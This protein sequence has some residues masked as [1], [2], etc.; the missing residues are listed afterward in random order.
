MLIPPGQAYPVLEPTSLVA[1][2]IFQLLFYYKNRCRTESNFAVFRLQRVLQD[3]EATQRSPWA[4]KMLFCSKLSVPSQ[5]QYLGWSQEMCP[6]A[7]SPAFEKYPFLFKAPVSSGTEMCFSSSDIMPT[8][9]FCLS[10]LRDWLGCCGKQTGFLLMS[11]GSCWCLLVWRISRKLTGAALKTMGTPSVQGPWVSHHQGLKAGA[12]DVHCP[13][14][15]LLIPSCSSPQLW[16]PPRHVTEALGSCSTDVVLLCLGPTEQ[17]R[18]SKEHMPQQWPF[19]AA[20]CPACSEPYVL[21]A[22]QALVEKLCLEWGRLGTEVQPALL[23]HCSACPHWQWESARRKGAE[24]MRGVACTSRGFILRD[25]H[26]GKKAAHRWCNRG[27]WNT[28]EE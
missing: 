26:S 4:P 12:W 5:G 6:A 10:L 20:S 25:F 27:L 14:G 21:P 24:V 16:V 22:P 17:G 1:R 2:V 9:C 15:V 19:P 11:V 28:R 7:I 23:A 3:S 18:T 13:G 8:P